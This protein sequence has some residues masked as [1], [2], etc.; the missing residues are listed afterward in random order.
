MLHQRYSHASLRWHICLSDQ[1]KFNEYKF[2]IKDHGHQLGIPVPR[3]ILCKQKRKVT[4]A[5]RSVAMEK[6]TGWSFSSL[7]KMDWKWV[8]YA[9]AQITITKSILNNLQN[10]W[11]RSPAKNQRLLYQ[12][13]FGTRLFWR[14]NLHTIDHTINLQQR[15]LHLPWENIALHPVCSARGSNTWK[16]P[17]WGDWR[18]TPVQWAEP[19]ADQPETVNLTLSRVDHIHARI[20]HPEGPQV[21]DPRAPEWEATVKAFWWW[22]KVV[23]QKR[24]T[25]SDWRSWPTGPPNHAR[26][27]L[28][29]NH[30]QTRPSMS[31]WCICCANVIFNKIFSAFGFIDSWIYWPSSSG[32]CSSWLV[33]SCWLVFF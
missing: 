17:N 26:A 24:K 14:M 12:L 23:K 1:S 29:W 21:N 2:W 13:P 11:W 19:L 20:G 7:K 10:D 27:S 5:L 32:H 16:K 31:I 3:W 30:W 9:G 25:A 15:V 6:R 8:F 33:S 4:T 18:L 28:R 22:D